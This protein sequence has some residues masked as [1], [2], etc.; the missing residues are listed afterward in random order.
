MKASWQLIALLFFAAGAGFA[1]SSQIGNLVG[2]LAN[3]GALFGCG[4]VASSKG[5]GAGYIFSEQLGG[6]PVI[7]N[8]RLRR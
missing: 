3:Q 7:M 6:S 4:W 2:P 5:L 8:Q 1:G